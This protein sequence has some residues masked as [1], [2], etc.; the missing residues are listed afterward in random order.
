MNKFAWRTRSWFPYTLLQFYLRLFTIN[1]H[2]DKWESYGFSEA[3]FKIFFLFS[4]P[5]FSSEQ[6][7][8]ISFVAFLQHRRFHQ[9]CNLQREKCKYLSKPSYNNLSDFKWNDRKIIFC[10]SCMGCETK[11]LKENVLCV[12]KWKSSRKICYQ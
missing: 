5:L 4:F 3:L 9:L 11:N 6:Q 10:S 12:G 2:D 8:N 7:R 1:E